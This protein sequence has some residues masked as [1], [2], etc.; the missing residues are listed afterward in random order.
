VTSSSANEALLFAADEAER[1]LT[2]VGKRKDYYKSKRNVDS[3]RNGAVGEDEIVQQEVIEAAN[4]LLIVSND[5]SAFQNL[6]MLKK[7]SHAPQIAS[8]HRAFLVL[9]TQCLDCVR[10]VAA[11]EEINET[12]EKDAH[13]QA[14]MDP[15]LALAR[16]AHDLG[17]PFHLPLYQRLMETVAITPAKTATIPDTVL[18]IAAFVTDTLD[19][20]IDCELF[21]PSLLALIHGQN[22][23]QVVELMHAMR[24]RHGVKS[25]DPKSVFDLYTQT[26][27]VLKKSFVEKNLTWR[28]DLPEA[29][30]TEMAVLLEPSVLNL[31]AEI[32]KQ[33]DEQEDN[34][35]R[36]LNEAVDELADEE[37]ESMMTQFEQDEQ[38]EEESQIEPDPLDKIITAIITKRVTDITAK[39]LFADMIKHGRV[40]SKNGSSSILAI[41]REIHV[42][43][44]TQELDY[45]ADADSSESSSD[46]EDRLFT[47]LAP[48]NQCHDHLS[49]PDI[50]RQVVKLN[51]G[52]ELT[53]TRRYQEL[54]W[55][56]DAEKYAGDMDK[57]STGRYD[58]TDTE[59]TSDGDDSGDE[60]Y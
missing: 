25:F 12:T 43:V 8:L 37:A 29:A 10:I 23:S 60:D 44:E 46:D 35:K 5:S 3:V 47:K 30:V 31:S 52:S 21:R 20:P 1:V 6:M 2:Q 11:S 17:F 56:R 41:P 16:R 14:L 28:R 26:H 58:Y 55:M 51:Q 34:I 7:T 13:L 38:E 59:E 15:A 57:C 39:R 32:E 40:R 9:T 19:A 48:P 27:D 53:F 50:T 24:D 33:L 54:L 45:W 36:A 22:F 4:T 49:L 42:S 18:E